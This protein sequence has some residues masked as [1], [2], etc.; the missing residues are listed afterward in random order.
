MH[1]AGVPLMAGTDGGPYTVA[2]FGLHEELA[3]LVKLD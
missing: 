3:L 2:G 1:R